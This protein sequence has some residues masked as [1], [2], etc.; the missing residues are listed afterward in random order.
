MDCCKP[1]IEIT[2]IVEGCKDMA[3]VTGTFTINVAPAVQPNPL[4]LTPDG[5][6]LGDAQVG[7]ALSEE[8]TEVSGGTPPYSF[9]VSAGAVPDGLAL[10]SVEN[11]DGTETV[12]IEGMPTTAS[13]PATPD[14]FDLTVTDSLGAS[15]TF[16]A[17][18]AT[19]KKKI[20]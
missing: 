14:S 5:G 16:K 3:Q 8:V 18:K 11:P 7:V 19:A 4:T 6:A 15:A 17:A 10:N 12:N 2:I 9:A 1:K 20:S 13:D